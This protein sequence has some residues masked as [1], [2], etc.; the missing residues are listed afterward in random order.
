MTSYDVH[1]PI[2]GDVIDLIIADHY[3]M[4]HLLRQMRDDSGDRE[5]A[6]LA[7]AA[8][9]VAH[10]EAEERHV[11]PALRKRAAEVGGHEVEHGK[12]EHAEGTEALLAVMELKGTDTKAYEDAVEELSRLASH[13]LVEEELTILN[14]ARGDVP[15]KDRRELGATFAAE[16][17]RQVDSDCGSLENLRRLVADAKQSGHLPTPEERVEKA[18]EKLEE[19][20]REASR[21]AG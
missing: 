20:R 1:R 18:E 15:L 11:Y 2:G 6:R 17:Q 7:F 8:V 5:A 16:R 12:E 13:H 10:A 21:S 3:L 4:E 14:P 9:H 19:A